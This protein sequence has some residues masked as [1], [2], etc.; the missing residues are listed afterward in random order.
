MAP[1][2]LVLRLISFELMN[3]DIFATI[4]LPVLMEAY[5]YPGLSAL[6]MERRIVWT[7]E[8]GR[9][10]HRQRHSVPSESV[11]GLGILKKFTSTQAPR[12]AARSRRSPVPGFIAGCFVKSLRIILHPARKGCCDCPLTQTRLIVHGAPP[13]NS[14]KARLRLFFL[15]ESMSLV[16]AYLWSVFSF[17]HFS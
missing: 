6:Q 3:V 11:N 7:S 8:R 4:K 5:N 2:M 12:L 9:L 15:P 16:S 14:I 1:L 10:D 17:D 13:K